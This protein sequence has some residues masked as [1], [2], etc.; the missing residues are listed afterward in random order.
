[1]ICHVPHMWPIQPSWHQQHATDLNGGRTTG[2]WRIV[3]AGAP[4]ISPDD[5]FSS[6]QY[7]HSYQVYIYLSILTHLVYFHRIYIHMFKI[8]MCVN[9][10][11]NAASLKITR[12]RI[13]QKK[14][15]LNILFSLLKLKTKQ[16]WFFLS[17]LSQ[18]ISWEFENPNTPP[19]I[20]WFRWTMINIKKWGFLIQNQNIQF[21]IFL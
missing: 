11:R 8:Q 15:E 21:R 6:N 16:I 12:L 4:Q 17:H 9:F 14:C 10:R 18:L 19:I 13:Q 7:I 5:G 2:S 20:I 3:R 1:M